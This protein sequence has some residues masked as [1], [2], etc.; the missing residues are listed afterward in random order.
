MTLGIVL[1]MAFDARMERRPFNGSAPRPVVPAVSLADSRQRLTIKMS[2]NLS[3]LI[4]PRMNP[5]SGERLMML[6]GSDLFEY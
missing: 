4:L 3:P 5:P 1:A 6:A 2:P